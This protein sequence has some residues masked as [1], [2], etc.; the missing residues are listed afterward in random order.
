MSEYKA[1]PELIGHKVEYWN[2][3]KQTKPNKP[4]KSVGTVIR[5]IKK[6]NGC[7]YLVEFPPTI[8]QKGSFKMWFKR[9]SIIQID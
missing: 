6:K 9:S 5:F 3:N 7:N 2:T 4:F 1:G 8:N